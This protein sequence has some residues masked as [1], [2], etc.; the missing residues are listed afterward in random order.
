MGVDLQ[1]E[2]TVACPTRS[3]AILG[4]NAAHIAAA[5]YC[6]SSATKLRILSR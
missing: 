6:L 3:L 2:R 1:R 5:A 4:D